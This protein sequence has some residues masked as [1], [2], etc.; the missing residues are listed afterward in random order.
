ME[1]VLQSI[2]HLCNLMLLKKC[3]GCVH[4][5]KHCFVM[6]FCVCVEQHCRTLYGCV[7]YSTVY[8]C[9]PLGC[10]TEIIIL[11]LFT[12]LFFRQFHGV[13]FHCR[14]FCFL[15]FFLFL[16]VFFCRITVNLAAQ[17]HHMW[18]IIISISWTEWTK[19]N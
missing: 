2:G 11:S 8:R 1:S 3:I 5:N 19:C 9:I 12:T 13:S 16:C 10:S 17:K 6:C 4:P 15:L 14:I 18:Y 7:F